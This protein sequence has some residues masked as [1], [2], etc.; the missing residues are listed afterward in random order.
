MNLSTL[1][2]FWFKSF[3][4]R[5]K[6]SDESSGDEAT[7]LPFVP[8]GVGVRA[9][10]VLVTVFSLSISVSLTVSVPIPIPLS[11]STFPGARGVVVSGAMG[12]GAGSVPT[13]SCRQTTL[14]KS[15]TVAT[16]DPVHFVVYQ[17]SH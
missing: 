15:F 16:D 10:A 17:H 1:S 2:I 5:R 8:V 14:K 6:K 7:P 4:F 11:L 9:M 13:Q 12:V 3:E